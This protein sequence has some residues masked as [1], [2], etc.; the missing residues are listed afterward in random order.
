[1]VRIKDAT[2]YKIKAGQSNF[3]PIENPLPRFGVDGF[4]MAIRFDRSAWWSPEDWQGDKD[5]N[6]WNK[7]KGVTW[8]LSWNDCSSAMIAWRP[9]GEK[10]VFDLM[11][12]TNPGCGKWITTRNP[13]QVYAGEVAYARAITNRREVYYEIDY[14]G[15]ITEYKHEW[16]RPWPWIAREVGTSVGGANNSPGPYGGK[17]SQDMKIEAAFRLYR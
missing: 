16:R 7:G 11:P 17:A 10:Y 4:E 6:D 14:F 15:N 13:V 12:Y 9:S 3:N 2:T 8:Y 5:R 1:M